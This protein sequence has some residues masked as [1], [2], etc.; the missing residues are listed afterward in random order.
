MFWQE[1]EERFVA[2]GRDPVSYWDYEVGHILHLGPDE[3]SEVT[4]ADLMGAVAVFDALY[5]TDG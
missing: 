1:F 5:R 3:V 2:V 4:P